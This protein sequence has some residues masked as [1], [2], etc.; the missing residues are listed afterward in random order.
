MTR[1]EIMLGLNSESIS[2]Y[3]GQIELLVVDTCALTINSAA[4]EIYMDRHV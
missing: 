3:A 1:F 4:W 2:R